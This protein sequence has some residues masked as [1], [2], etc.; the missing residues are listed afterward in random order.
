M[1][2][3]YA[4]I[5]A[6]LLLVITVLVLRFAKK[7]RYLFTGWF[8]YLGTL[9]PVIGIIQ[10]ADHSM[11]DR[12]TYIPLT[13]LFIIIAWGLPELLKKLPHREIILSIFSFVVLSALAVCTFFQERYWKDSEAL[14]RHALAVTEN[15]YS[16]HFG[17]A[18]TFL[19]QNKFDMAVIEYQEYLKIKP[20]TAV[21]LNMLGVALS[22]QGKYDEAVKPFEEALRIKPD[23]VEPMNVLAWTLAV[24]PK[25]TSH[26][27]D[28]AV[29]LAQRACEL[30]GNKIPELLDTLAVA[31]AA[32]GDFDKA[33]KTSQ[34]AL[35]L[36]K[37]AEQKTLK[38]EIEN[39]LDL[40]KAGKPYV[41]TQ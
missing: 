29:K 36:C 20:H 8:W 18:N 3:L 7:H 31:Y 28:K 11:A 34:K 41:E 1:S 2:I 17:L 9:V 22:R 40:Y 38:K 24:D 26:N 15:N 32:A 25:M 10:V 30:T 39:R 4:V 37:S 5:S 23:W 27:P 16:A 12:Y 35:E 14:C 19:S 6:V 13:G 33:V 21:I